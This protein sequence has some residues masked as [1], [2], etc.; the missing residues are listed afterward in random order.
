MDNAFVLLLLTFATFACLVGAHHF[1]EVGLNKKVANGALL[2]ATGTV[3][4]LVL[5]SLALTRT[6]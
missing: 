2:L 3:L 1:L 4:L 6:S 5:L